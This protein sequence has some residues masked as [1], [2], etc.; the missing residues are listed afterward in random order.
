MHKQ[1]MVLV[2]RDTH[3][4]SQSVKTKVAVTWWKVECFGDPIIGLIYIDLKYEHNIKCEHN[5]KY[6]HNLKYDKALKYED[7]IKF[8][9]NLESEGN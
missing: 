3:L 9:N 7:N 2:S 1:K 8:Q 4:Q 6:E 5:I